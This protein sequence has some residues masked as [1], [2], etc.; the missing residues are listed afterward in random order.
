[1]RF[2]G[3]M[4]LIKSHKKLELHPLFRRCIF[5]KTTGQE[6]GGRGGGGEGVQTYPKPFYV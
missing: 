2:S 6:R 4:W 5:G 3:K 1:M